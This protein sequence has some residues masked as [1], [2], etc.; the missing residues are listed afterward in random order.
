MSL[1]QVS[2]AGGAPRRVCENC[3]SNGPRGFS[4]DGSRVLAQK[5]YYLDPFL[6]QIEQIDIASGEVKVVLSHPNRSL[7]HPYFSWDDKW[8]TF[9]M[10]LDPGQP[11]HSHHSR[12]YI[13]PVEN[14]V[15]A[16]ESRWIPL[17]S[18]EYS[19]DKPQ[20]SPD[21]STLY[22]TSNRDGHICLWSQRL[23]P[24]SKHPEGAP[25]AIQHLHDQQGTRPWQI[26]F[27]Q[28]F[29]EL[30]VARDKIVT[31][32]LEVHSDIWMTQLAPGK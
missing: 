7:F 6:G 29:T 25:F 16:G 2:T 24:K 3:A 12:I 28:F 1:Y 18:G 14:W 19:E 8:M 4:S 5:S 20:L 17:T 11:D 30:S 21:G 32:I 15:P 13:T 31:D 9:K 26:N 23:N 10:Q 27:L 22:F